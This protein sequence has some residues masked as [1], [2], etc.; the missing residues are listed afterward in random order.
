[1]TLTESQKRRKNNMVILFAATGVLGGHRFYARRPWSG[2]ALLVLS[3]TEF[4]LFV[5][6][7][8]P[9]WL[10]AFWAVC[11]WLEFDMLAIG[12]NFLL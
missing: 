6:N 5:H 11:A 8:Y 12:L 9:W 3:V 10:I 7:I 4:T 1:M 2:I